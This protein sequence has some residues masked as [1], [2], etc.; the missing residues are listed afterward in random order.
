MAC[1][2]LLMIKRFIASVALEWFLPSVLPRV[3]VQITN[4]GTSIVALVTFERLLS[5][6]HPH[7]VNFQ[8]RSFNARISARCASVWLFTR[9]HLLVLLEVV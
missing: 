6:V 3:P 2:T 1:E 8:F 7:H 9:V 5:C 4:R